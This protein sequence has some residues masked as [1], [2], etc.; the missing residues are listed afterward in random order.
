MN[1]DDKK[2]IRYK[3]SNDMKVVRWVL[4]QQLK[5]SVAV[6]KYWKK[7]SSDWRGSR[8]FHILVIG[9]GQK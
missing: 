3:D 8:M 6:E 9:K 2:V 4:N 1:S 7:I 5:N